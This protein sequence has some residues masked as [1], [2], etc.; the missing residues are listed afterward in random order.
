M[1]RW[2]RNEGEAEHLDRRA[3]RL[4]EAYAK[5]TIVRVHRPGGVTFDGTMVDERQSYKPDGGRCGSITLRRWSDGRVQ[6]S[7]V[8]FNLLDV[9]DVTAVGCAS[10]P[11]L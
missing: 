4:A 8:T 11:P 7:A 2:S 1:T 6:G 9:T 3:G 5:S 10:D